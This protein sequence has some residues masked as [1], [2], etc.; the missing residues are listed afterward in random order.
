MD[1]ISG[2]STY[3]AGVLSINREA[4]TAQTMK[5]L[6]SRVAYVKQ[7]DIFFGDLTVRD[8]LTYTALLRMPAALPTAKKHEEVDRVLRL[9]RLNK[10]EDSQISSLSGGER[11]RVNIGTELLTDP[12]VLLLDEPTSG[13]EIY[14]LYAVYYC[15]RLAIN[16]GEQPVITEDKNE[17]ANFAPPLLFVSGSSLFTFTIQASTPPVLCPYSSC[18]RLWLVNMERLSLPV[19]ISRVRV[20]SGHLIA[21][22]SCL[23]EKWYISVPQW[24][25]CST[26]DSRIS[27]AQMATMLLTIG[28]IY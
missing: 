14:M 27:P 9:L 21:S 13:K 1:V 2:R 11:K 17:R 23:M 12:S 25:R 15:A 26:C 5:R 3:Q 28:W 19:F 8:Q 20:C 10:V 7:Q 6:M 22:C 18:C 24:T 16:L 4:T